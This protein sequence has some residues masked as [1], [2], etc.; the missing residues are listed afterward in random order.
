M[1][2]RRTEISDID[3]TY[4]VRARTRQN[5]VSRGQLEA[6]GFTAEAV[7]AGY[8]AGRYAGWVCEDEGEI[9]GFG[10]GDAATGEILVIAVLPEYEGKGIGKRL[11]ELVSE[12]LSERGCR[13][14]WLAASPDPAIRAHG[15]YRAHGWAPKGGKDA[16]GDEIL[17]RET[18][19]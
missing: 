1:E 19:G 14:L 6:W 16:N 2:F 8:L 4:G 17:V 9:V 12:S 18:D 10:T 7:A 5:P 15:F 13:R 11:L 3:A